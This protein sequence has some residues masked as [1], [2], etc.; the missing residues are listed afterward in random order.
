[1]YM[2]PSFVT[3]DCRLNACSTEAQFYY[4]A[5]RHHIKKTDL[6]EIAYIERM[7]SFYEPNNDN[8]QELIV[9]TDNDLIVSRRVYEILKTGS[10]R[11]LISFDI[12]IR[13]SFIYDIFFFYLEYLRFMYFFLFPPQSKS[14]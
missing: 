12:M 4:I 14:S 13:I 9:R 6:E 10:E 7:F 3:M 2:C 11:S 1:M 5:E 8:V